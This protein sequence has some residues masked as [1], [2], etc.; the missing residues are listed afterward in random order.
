MVNPNQNDKKI[1]VNIYVR[2]STEKQTEGMSDMAQRMVCERALAAQQAS[3]KAA[4]KTLRMESVVYE[5][6][7]G[8]KLKKIGRDAYGRVVKMRDEPKY[9]DAVDFDRQVKLVDLLRRAPAGSF[10]VVARPDRLCRN[11]RKFDDY[12]DLAYRRDIVIGVCLEEEN[13]V[14][15][16]LFTNSSD[17]TEQIRQRIKQAEQESRNMGER[18]KNRVAMLRNLAKTVPQL[19]NLFMGSTPPYG[20]QVDRVA[21]GDKEFR[22]LVKNPEEQEIVKR[23]QTSP[24]EET[25]V[26]IARL[27]NSQEKLRRG[28]P[29]TFKQIKDVYM[30]QEDPSP[31]MDELA[32]QLQR[33]TV[34]ASDSMMRAVQNVS[35]SR[36][37]RQT[38]SSR[39]I[40]PRRGRGVAASSAA[41]SSS[42]SSN[43]VQ[44]R[45]GRGVA[46]SSAASS[47]ASSS[48]KF[49]ESMDF[50]SDE[51]SDEE[52][53]FLE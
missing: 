6:A 48:S 45:R 25:F 11:V 14:I 32:D 4:G 50:E 5:H 1:P 19:K 29:W 46:A 53:P 47:S 18:Q 43:S 37:A 30:A 27:L 34:Q 38:T 21:W 24:D 17:D 51:D 35:R 15:P 36:M 2:V 13:G 22:V 49:V 10:I 8:Y 41:S 7:S 44:S 23:I 40:Q 12:I 26:Q 9:Y 20:Y 42:S 16:M 39:S 31:S 52:M 33:M 3:L 28:L